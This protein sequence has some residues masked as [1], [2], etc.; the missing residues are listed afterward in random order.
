MSVEHKMITYFLKGVFIF[1]LTEN[2][3]GNKER[4]R[5]GEKSLAEFKP[6][7]C[8]FCG[9]AKAELFYSSDD[10]TCLTSFKAVIFLQ[11]PQ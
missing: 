3:C 1:Y 8:H 5:A 9:M 4:V 10:T 7:M 2:D 11:W 6:E